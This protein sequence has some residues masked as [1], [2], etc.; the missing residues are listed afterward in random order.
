MPKLDQQ[1]EEL[2]E[3]ALLTTHAEEADKSRSFTNDDLLGL[4]VV[5][6][7][8]ELL[9][10][11]QTLLDGH[12]I[13]LLSLDGQTCYALRSTEVAEKLQRLHQDELMVYQNV[14]GKGIQGIWT[15]TLK[16]NTGMVQTVINKA[17]KVLE[18]RDLIKS[19]KNIKNPTQKSYILSHLDPGEDVKG[20]PWHTDGELDPDLIDIVSRIVVA[21]VEQHSW[22]TG[23]ERIDSGR[24]RSISPMPPLSEAKDSGQG[25]PASNG[26]KRKRDLDIEDL[27]VPL[28]RR[29][30]RFETIE[31]QIPLGPNHDGY[32]SASDIHHFVQNGQI[33]RVNLKLSDMNDLLEMLVLDEVLERIGIGYRS[34]RGVKATSGGVSRGRG[35]DGSAAE[36]NG[37]THVPCGRCPVFQ[38]CEEGGPVN[39]RNCVYFDDWLKS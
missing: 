5:D 8:Q 7:S 4:G 39:A 1:S 12:Y 2:Y 29:S 24:S 15:K 11:C 6:N 38:L 16:A 28:A 19:V 26:N 14:E 30:N 22:R 13:R 21:Y 35:V 33:V 31:T 20:G 36:G 18:S 27:D 3:K 23:S 9:R 34:I 10:L 32:P 17:I 37:L 25:N